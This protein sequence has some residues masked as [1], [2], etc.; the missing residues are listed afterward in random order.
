MSAAGKPLGRQ[1][2]D[3]LISQADWGV[4]MPSIARVNV[5]PLAKY[6]ED[7]EARERGTGRH[8]IH[9]KTGGFY[10]YLR[11][12]RIEAGNVLAVEY[13]G[14]DGTIWVRPHHEFFDGRFVE[15]EP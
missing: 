10:T 14:V 11:D 15:V 5:K 1:I 7:L 2:L 13:Q 9:R 4:G 3:D 12:V 6:V 8:F